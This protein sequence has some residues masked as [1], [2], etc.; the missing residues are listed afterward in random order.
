[1]ILHRAAAEGGAV[2]RAALF[3]A[4][5][6]PERARPVQPRFHLSSSYNDGITPDRRRGAAPDPLAGPAAVP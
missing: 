1:M 5:T 4:T 2:R 3:E 6:G